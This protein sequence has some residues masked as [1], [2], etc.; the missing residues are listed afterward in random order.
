MILDINWICENQDAFCKSMDSRNY[1]YLL[2]EV[3]ELNVKIKKTKTEIQEF[4]TKKNAIDK[5]IGIQ[6]RDNQDTSNE[7]TESIKLGNS[8]AQLNKNTENITKLKY[9]LDH[10]PNILLPDVPIGID[11]NDNV[12]IRRHGDIP[13]FDFTPKSHHDLGINLEMMDSNYSAQISG[14]R[15]STLTN[16][17]ALMVRA[18]QNFMLDINI[19]SGHN[20]VHHP[21]LVKN[22]AMYNTGQ[23]PKFSEDSYVLE[24]S[25]M[26]LIPT[27]EV[28]LTNIVANIV[29]KQKE[30]PMRLT[31]YS[32]CFR[33]EAGSAGKDTKGLMRQ[34]QFEKVELVSITT[35]DESNNELERIVSIAEKVLQKLELPY[36]VMLLCSGDTGFV[37][38][39]TYDI[40]V[41]LPHQNKYRE[42]SSCSNCTDF[43]ARRMNTKYEINNKKKNF[44]HTLNGSS[45][46]IG[47]TLLAILENYQNSDGSI[48]IPKQ[49]QPYM[50]KK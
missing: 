33:S 10:F 15:F 29:L 50:K 30:L 2:S 48:R 35:Q 42:I 1:T 17:L 39:K 49:L 47:R 5:A 8:I 38:S 34:H 45:L 16:D 40:E 26:R 41:W 14:S 9:I 6:K 46:A 28:F 23:L 27:S 7:M 36:R 25:D 20:E 11:E 22:A 3:I 19:E 12:E 44:V 37:S 32:P 4:Q 31:A 13:D 43:Q 18:L 21:C 24:N